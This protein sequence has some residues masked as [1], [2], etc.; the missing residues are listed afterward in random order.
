MNIL[1]QHELY[2][3]FQLQFSIELSG[4]FKTQNMQID[5]TEKEI[6]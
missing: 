3:H 4:L 6:F 5:A 1:F 2:R